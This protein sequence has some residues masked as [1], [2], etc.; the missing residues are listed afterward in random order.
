LPDV[1]RQYNTAREA[2]DVDVAA[3]IVGEA[4][5][6]VHT[7][8]PAADIVRSMVAHRDALLGQ[9]RVHSSETH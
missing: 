6:L 7:V 1:Q 4:A 8:A 9:R 5:D 2:G 3:T